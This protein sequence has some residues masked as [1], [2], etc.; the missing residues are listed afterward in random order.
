MPLSV[1]NHTWSLAVEAQFYLLWPLLFVPLRARSRADRDPRGGA[2][3]SWRSPA[4]GGGDASSFAD[5]WDIYDR[6]D[7]HATGPRPRM[8]ARGWGGQRLHG[9]FGDPRPAA[10]RAR[11]LA[12]L[13]LAGSRR[14]ALFGF[15]LAGGGRG[16]RRPV[17]RRRGSARRRWRWVGRMSYGLYLWHYPVMRAAARPR[18]ALV[19][20]SCVVG[21]ARRAGGGGA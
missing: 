14:P 16:A 1:L 3:S 6:A 11:R 20:R 19:A 10:A 18:L 15:T 12:R 13:Q 4:G 17:A 8:P 21:S 7:T 9:R 2:V 5:P